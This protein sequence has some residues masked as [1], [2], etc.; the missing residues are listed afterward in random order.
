MTTRARNRRIL[1]AILLYG[2]AA[3]SVLFWRE[4]AFDPVMVGIN[5]GMAT[6]GLVILHFKWRRN[7]PRISPSK[8]KDIFS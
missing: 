5:M 4:G 1:A 8:A 2:F 6:L 7:E 3:G